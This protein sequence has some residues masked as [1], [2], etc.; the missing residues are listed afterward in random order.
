LDRM[1]RSGAPAAVIRVLREWRHRPSVL[2]RA[3]TALRA[4]TVT[5]SM[6]KRVMFDGGMDVVL[7]LMTMYR[8]NHHVQDRAAAVIANVAF[9]C[10]HR[11]R[12]IARQGAVKN[13]VDGMRTFPTD[14]HI[15]LRGA[16]TIRN[17]AHDAQV[18]QY[19]A[20]NEGAV[21]AIAAT[22]L[23]FR[24]S[25][26]NP[27]LRYQCVCALESLC[28]EDER[29]RQRVVD[30]DLTP[31]QHLQSSL[32]RSSA[33][34]APCEHD[35][36]TLNEHGDVVVD[37]EQVLITDTTSAF[38]H[39]SALCPGNSSLRLMASMSASSGS[40]WDRI[41][42]DP[43]DE[44]KHANLD[45]LAVP[46]VQSSQLL[47]VAPDRS[48]VQSSDPSDGNKRSV[49]RAIVHAMRRAPD[50]LHLLET[51]LSLLTLI[52]LHR[53]E[54]Q[55]RIGELG[56]LAV[57][58]AATRRHPSSRSLVSNACALVRCLCLQEANRARVTS[59]L[60]VLIAAAR[61]HV[62]DADVVREVASALSNAV[63]E[64]EKNRAWVVSNGGVGVMVRA[65]ESCGQKDVMVL[66]AGICALRNF[67]DS[68]YSG[69]V[70]ASKEGAV[71]AAVAALDT[72]KDASSTG[73][74]IV[75]EQA[76]LFLVD[77]GRLAPQ[78]L[79]E[80]EEIDAADWIENALAKLDPSNYAELHFGGDRLIGQL[81]SSEEDNSLERKQTP[82][83]LPPSPTAVATKHYSKGL[84]S[85][86]S[87]PRRTNS[88]RK[89]QSKKRLNVGKSMPISPEETGRKSKRISA[90]F[91]KN[92]LLS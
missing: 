35:I 6:R 63:F 18:N 73:Q 43:A 45:D 27:D 56:G 47:S 61:D 55:T 58:I 91:L 19:I 22:L 68:S 81:T 8:T 67:I 85:A 77:V 23:R 21:E 4:F 32:S 5:D 15:Q 87:L 72:T 83:A 44:G 12:R 90:R 54:A 11:K 17:L 71:R 41:S 49:I 3:L 7:E 86:F 34:A 46:P 53:S 20:G 31:P 64:N 89:S 40:I 84:F 38:R 2:A 37:E 48:A 78:T 42:T 74:C 29:N 76:V 9:G 80:M 39:G 79:Q 57:A 75:Q 28:R 33:T 50:D 92:A 51:A 65:M 26:T 10:T 69:A 82:G 25:S 59:G 66:E 24:G 14:E 30:I 62:R 13:I 1:Q 70:A 88:R 36:E 60:L 52:S 16:L